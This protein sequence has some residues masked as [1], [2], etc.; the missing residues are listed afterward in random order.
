MKKILHLKIDTIA[1]EHM[2][3]LSK[4]LNLTRE[5]YV[6]AALKHFNTLKKRKLL[7]ELLAFESELVAMDSLQFLNEIDP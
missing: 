2:E 7:G 6:G 3:S 4:E 5:E 1:F